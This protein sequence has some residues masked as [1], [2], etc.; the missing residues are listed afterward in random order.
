MLTFQFCFFL[1][2]YSYVCVYF[3]SIKVIVQ[4]LKKKNNKSCLPMYF[5]KEINDM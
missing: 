5:M 4:T 2:Y 1:F 3:L